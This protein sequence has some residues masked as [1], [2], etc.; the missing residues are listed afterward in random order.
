LLLIPPAVARR[1]A[2][3]P[4]VM[5]LVAVLVGVLSVIGGIK[6]SLAWDTPAGPSIVTTATVLFVASLPLSRALW[7]A[8]F[9]KQ[10]EAHHHDH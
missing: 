5:A 7:R 3:T 2:R 4:E 10:T 9:P 8:F 6:A 1:F